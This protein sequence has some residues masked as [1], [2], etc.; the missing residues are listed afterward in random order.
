MI[1]GLD[2]DAWLESVYTGPGGAYDD[3]EEDD[4]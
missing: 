3:S 1:N 4:E 2:Y